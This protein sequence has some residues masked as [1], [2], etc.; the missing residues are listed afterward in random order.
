M[1]NTSKETEATTRK[2]RVDKALRHAGRW[3]ILDFVNEVESQ[4]LT[5]G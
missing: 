2:L 4:P 1:P 5:H 3:P